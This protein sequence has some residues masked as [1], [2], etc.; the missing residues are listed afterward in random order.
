MGDMKDSAFIT[1][2][3]LPDLT[4]AFAQSVKSAGITSPEDEL[5]VSIIGEPGVGKSYIATKLAEGIL[6]SHMHTMEQSVERDNMHD[7]ILWSVHTNEHQEIIQYDEASLRFVDQ[8]YHDFVAAE[9]GKTPVPKRIFPGVTFVEH[10]NADTEE[11]SDIVVRVKFSEMQRQELHRIHKEI[12]HGGYDLE[13]KK[14]E[15]AD[16]AAQGCMMEIETQGFRV[17]D[18]PLIEFFDRQNNTDNEDLNV[19]IY[20][21]DDDDADLGDYA[22][23]HPD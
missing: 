21:L 1:S 13:S 10:P 12:E 7:L 16:I 8:D 23:I 15:L 4:A 2:D 3:N 14:Q 19:P 20:M 11:D 18:T 17:D 22:G 9:Q 6:G 5:K